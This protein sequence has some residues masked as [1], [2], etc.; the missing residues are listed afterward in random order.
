MNVSQRVRAG[1]ALGHLLL[2]VMLALSVFVMHTVGHPADSHTAGMDTASHAPAPTMH[3]DAAVPEPGPPAAP[4]DAHRAA[5]DLRHSS[6]THPPMTAM[7]MLSLCLA[8]LAGA[9]ALTA[10]LRSAFAR[11]PERLT[12]ASVRIPVLRQPVPPPR[13]LGLTRLSVLRL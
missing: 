2:F 1:G 6:S 11:R 12:R 4:T 3:S 13:G 10:L 9:C 7:D 5:S 8:V